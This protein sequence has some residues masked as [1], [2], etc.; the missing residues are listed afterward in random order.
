[1]EGR[2]LLI[3]DVDGTLLGDDDAL[4]TFSRWYAERD[5]LT[6]VYNSGR[7]FDSVVESVRDTLL[8]EPAAIIGGVGTQVCSY[9]TGKTIGDWLANHDGWNSNIVHA[10]LSQH[11]DV[12]LQPDEF[13]SPHKISYFAREASAEFL[14]S[15][16]QQL[17]AAGCSAEL[18]YSSR[19][20]L[21][22]LPAGIDK[23]TAAAFL[24][25]H[26][27]YSPRHVIVSGDSGNDLRMFQ[28]GF[29]G[30]VVANAHAELKQLDGA[31]V[32]QAESGFAAGVLQGLEHWMSMTVA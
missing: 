18:V 8:P 31:N 4:R 9:D 3:S 23:G 29:R 19:R 27:G 5:D 12:E 28:H 22:V 2:Y 14:A 1:M 16:K 26:L 7:L 20:D 24:A 11:D 21:D 10:V 30:V 6:L 13:L 17:A 32:F 15:L 25:E